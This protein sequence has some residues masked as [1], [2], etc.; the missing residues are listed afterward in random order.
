M[1][2]AKCVRQSRVF[3]SHILD[4]LRSIKSPTHHVCLTSD[5]R[6]DLCWWQVFLM[7]YNGISL[8]PTLPWSV[9]DAAFATHACLARC[10]SVSSTEYF[11]SVLTDFIL[12]VCTAIHHLK[13]LAVMVPIHLWGQHWRGRRI[14]L[15]CDNEAVVSV[16]N[17]GHT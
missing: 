7:Q 10:G 14:Q 12:T 13:L 17:T 4:L 15:F 8:I 11:H 1:S 3:V 5:F 9:P 16:I 2:V 6:K